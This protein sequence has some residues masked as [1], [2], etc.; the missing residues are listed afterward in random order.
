MTQIEDPGLCPDF[1]VTHDTFCFH[2]TEKKHRDNRGNV[3]KIIC[4][5]LKRKTKKKP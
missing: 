4:V 3:N 5:F 1:F 2:K